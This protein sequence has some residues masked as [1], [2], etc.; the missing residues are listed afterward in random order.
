MRL[1]LG[2]ITVG[3]LTALAAILGMPRLPASAAEPSPL[4]GSL[5]DT[6]PHVTKVLWIFMEN[7]SYG[8]GAKQ[9]PGN[10]SAPYIDNTLI[11][12]CGSTSDYHAATHPSYPNYLAATSGS[13]Q[14]WSSDTLGYFNV[15]SIFSQTDPSWRSYEE[16]MPVG[17]D[18]IWQTG[19]STTH[20][21]YVAKHNPAASYSALPVGAP[22][23]GDCPQNDEAL[24]TTTSGPLIS[25]IDAGTLP[26]FGFVT[27]GLCDD[28]H[29]VP[30]GD[31]SCPNPVA[32]GD[33]WLSK[34]IP[35]LTSGQ[36]YTSGNL[37]IDVTWD[38][39]SGGTAGEDCITSSTQDCLVPDIV[40]S[41]YTQHVVSGT[42]FSHYSL[43]KMTET[44]LGLP[45]LGGAAD[46][47]TND[48]CVPFGLCPQDGV[49][50]A[51][52]FTDSCSGLT[53]SFDGSGST[54]PGSGVTSYAWN[55][56]DGSTGTGETAAHAYATSGTYPVTLTV[57][58]GTGAVGS[59]TNDVSV[60]GS[61]GTPISYV[62]AASATG[63]AATET[64]TIPSAV[65]SG[66]E[67][68]LL[69]T[70]VSSTQPLTGPPGWTPVGS[71]AGTAISTEAWSRV[72]TSSDPSQ[73]VTVNFGGTFKGGVQ[74]LAYAGTSA[75]EPVQAFD[76]QVRH[77]TTSSAAT[78]PVSLTRSGCWTVS[79]WA[80]KSSAVSAWTLPS[81][82]LA[83]S[84]SY[85]SGGGRIDAVAGDA[86]GPAP[87]GAAG[88]V[89]ATTDPPVKAATTWTVV[90]AAGP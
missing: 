55:F 39:G 87:A 60:S 51:A 4:C 63:S 64:V 83:R 36:D 31:T 37:A 81:G 69:A 71:N 65:T 89:T 40:I 75:T 6:T 20:Q 10:P 43:L 41:P 50:P 48:M 26:K 21:Y 18:H 76:S 86:G 79:Y 7:Q 44:L 68:L 19:N 22:T 54:A 42:D 34:W 88:D 5:A 74:L 11:G 32:S 38:E 2:Y 84:T 90:V 17:C 77:A 46:A 72:A 1:R 30:A 57:T 28:M 85:G 58:S 25:D 27:P 62:A 53:C 13:T 3:L 82:E 9:I 49:P 66:D 70:D 56:G 47:E 67:M 73:K 33:A 59:V 16:F 29:L 45:Y 61:A 78:P 80:A 24:G 8:A 12:Q 52:S 35:I 23:S 14:G 15:P